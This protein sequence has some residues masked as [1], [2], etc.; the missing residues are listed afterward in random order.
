MHAIRWPE[1]Y[2]PGFTDNFASNEMIVAGLSAS[3]V[4]PYLATLAAWPTYYAN[5]SDVAFYDE[6]GPI[7]TPGARFRFTTFGFSVE[8][9][10]NECVPP[11]EDAPGRLAWH[12]WVEGDENSRLDVHHAWLLEDLEGGRLRILTQET[13]KGEP[14][15]SLAAANPNPMINGHQD[16][17]VG[18]VSAAR[19]RTPITTP[20]HS[21]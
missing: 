8:G 12:G 18:L 10:V 7:L 4:W 21:I 15:R 1:G 6:A 13:Q 17:L 11:R 3:E 16:W 5:A 2:V 14:A 19:K 9:L 20:S